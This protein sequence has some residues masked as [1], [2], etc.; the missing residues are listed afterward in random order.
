MARY[1]LHT[2]QIIGTELY[3]FLLIQIFLLSRKKISNKIVKLKFSTLN[4]IQ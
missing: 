1:S 2:L 4:A 3:F